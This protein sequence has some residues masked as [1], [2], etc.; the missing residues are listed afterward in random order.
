MHISRK[1]PVSSYLTWHLQVHRFFWL[2]IEL[3]KISHGKVGIGW[4]ISHLEMDWFTEDLLNGSH[5]HLV[6][7]IPVE[8]ICSRCLKQQ[9]SIFR[10]DS[11][12]DLPTGKTQKEASSA[13]PRFW[14]LSLYCWWFQYHPYMNDTESGFHHHHHHHHHHIPLK[15]PQNQHSYAMKSETDHGYPIAERFH[16]ES[17][18]INNSAVSH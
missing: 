3:S 1:G 6:T 10:K 14:E 8:W 12:V 16:Q 4:E 15:S 13:N 7:S 5:Q 2:L 11:L 9:N 18:A 17:E